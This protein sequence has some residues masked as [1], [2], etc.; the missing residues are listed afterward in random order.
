MKIIPIIILPFAILQLCYAPPVT[1]NK[2]GSDSDE[3]S[4]MKGLED[5][6]EYHRYLKEV[7]NAL[8]SDPEF[9]QKLE[10]ANETEIRS[11]RIAEELEF[12][13]HHVRTR[14]DEIKR[15]ELE[16]LKELTEK[17]R[18][19]ENPNSIIDDPVHHHLD[20][21]NPHT[22][23]IEDL[24]KLIAKTTQDLAEADR[25]RKEQFKQYELEK[26]YQKQEKLNHTNGDEREKLEKQMMEME[27]KHKKHEKLHEPGHKAQLEEVWEEQDQ[28]QQ[29]FDPKTFF[30]LHDVDGNG[31]WDQDEVKSLFIKELDKMYQQGAP[32]GR[33]EGTS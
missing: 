23:E 29:D 22:F 32:R 20:H 8:E 24:K 4:D 26:E 11:G 25:K 21:S 7:V 1:P 13:S 27:E 9:R 33:H 28:M 2:K 3:D 16:R 15:I 31:L 18:R 6:M 14:L 19:L 17:K 10:K 5:Y 12:V 30:M